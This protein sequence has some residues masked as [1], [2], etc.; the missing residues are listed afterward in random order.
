MSQFSNY[1]LKNV[2]K[3]IEPGPVVLVTTAF[4]DEQNI[5]TM[6]WHT[7]IDFE[8]PLIAC[9]ISNRNHSFELLKKSKD[10]VINIPTKELAKKVVGCGNTSGV[11]LDKFDYFHLTPLPAMTVK[12]PLIKECYACLECKIVDSSLSSKYNLFFLEVKRAWIRADKK[13]KKTPP[14]TLHHLGRG[15]FMIAGKTIKI[16]SK[17][18]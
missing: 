8:P 1:P 5:M 11:N 17:M 4:K 15:M 2:Y 12:A 13:T 18:K 14:A 10:C 9:V 7:M 6:S 16:P 3:L